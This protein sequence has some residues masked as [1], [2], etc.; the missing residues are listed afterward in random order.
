MI[1]IIVFLLLLSALLL[2]PAVLAQ[3]AEK[4]NV[5]II[6]FGVGGTS[7]LTEE[8]IFDIL[9]S[10]G[11]LSADERSLLGEDYK[12]D[13]ENIYINRQSANFDFPTA[14]L[15][16]D[17]MLEGEPDVLITLGTP[18]TQLA[19]NATTD[20]E[21]PPTILFTTVFNPFE[22]GIADAPCLKPANVTG[23]ESLT[24]YEELMPL[25]Q[26]Q[27]PA[28]QTLGVIYS[29]SEDTG[30]FGAER[31]AEIAEAMGITVQSV[32]V[33]TLKDLHPATRSLLDGGVDALL[34]PLDSITGIGL[35]TIVRMSNAYSVPIFYPHGLAVQ[36][37]A[38]ISLGAIRYYSRGENLGLILAA[39]LN[40]EIDIAR[41]GIYIQH[42][43]GLG[44]NLD[45]ARAQGIEI[46]P[47]LLDQ[48]LG[49]IDGGQLKILDE[50]LQQEYANIGVIRELED[51]LEA[52]Q[53]FLASLHC[54]DEIIAEQQAA[55]DADSG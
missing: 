48:A 17:A 26:I 4:P 52:D 7:E 3:S 41:T 36:L 5:A 34:L 47:A 28:L 55:L 29:S 1:R 44:V 10:Y 6:T 51:R 32:P 45:A 54:S 15:L 53:E 33:S 30:I 24:P 40:G 16:L 35:P 42:D 38:T 19:I 13:G 9:Q 25:L 43:I 27:D 31:I 50:G 2:A 39:H 12:L 37:G 46:A 18:M 21:D 20:M 22:V 14:N 11:F 49:M 23:T 8:G